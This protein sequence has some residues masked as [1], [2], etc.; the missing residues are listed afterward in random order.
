MLP[1]G[2]SFDQQLASRLT[3]SKNGPGLPGACGH[4]IELQIMTGLPAKY[5]CNRE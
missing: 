4:R 5:G 1:M 3:S 2:C